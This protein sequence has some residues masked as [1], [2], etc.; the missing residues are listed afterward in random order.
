MRQGDIE[1]R[2][3]HQ[4]EIIT[5]LRTILANITGRTHALPVSQDRITRALMSRE[6]REERVIWAGR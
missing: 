3:C 6:E 4:L 2:N 1:R 5:M